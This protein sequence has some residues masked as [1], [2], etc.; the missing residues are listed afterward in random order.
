MARESDTLSSF[1]F[2]M[3]MGATAGLVAGIL[4]APKSGEET[5]KDLQKTFTDFTDKVELHYNKARKELDLK[6]AKLK[7]VG[8]KIDKE[9][10]VKLIEEVIN[11]IKSDATVT[12]DV[13]SKIKTQLNKDWETAKVT[14]DT[15]PKTSGATK[16]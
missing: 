7:A 13:A 9:K 5:R 8:A 11:E 10:Y 4:L 1:V 14:F 12:S 16:K 15:T 2:G 3:A 6:L